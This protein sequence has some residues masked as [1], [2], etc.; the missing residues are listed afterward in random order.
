MTQ[1]FEDRFGVAADVRSWLY[2]DA[3]LRHTPAR[4]TRGRLVPLA[5]PTMPFW[6]RE[7]GLWLPLSCAIA[8]VGTPVDGSFTNGG[9][10]TFSI[11]VIGGTNDAVLVAI[12]CSTSFDDITA[13]TVGGVT[14]TFIDK[15]TGGPSGWN[16]YMYGAIPSGTGSKSVVVTVS[17]SHLILAGAAEYTGIGSFTPSGTPVH[18]DKNPDQGIGDNAVT[19]TTGVDNCW[20]FMNASTSAGVI[21]TGTGSTLRTSDASFGTWSILDSGA[22]VSPAGS[23]TMHVGMTV[24]PGAS[25]ALMFALPPAGGS[26]PAFGPECFQPI[27]Q[28]TNHYRPTVVM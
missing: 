27:G 10:H 24:H 14:A 22:A 12:G 18:Q 4:R 1:T 15:Y 3:Y 20:A 19:I 17:G 13:V 16:I 9:S 6:R 5:P 11:T 7:P 21:A 2:A 28:P 23:V 26:P 25:S 8:P